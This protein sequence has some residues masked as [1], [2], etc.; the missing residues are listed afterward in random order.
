MKI[1][2]SY[3]AKAKDLIEAGLYPISISVQF[4]GFSKIKYPTFGM[5]GPNYAMLKMS[6]E[7][8]YKIFNKQLAGLD[9]KTIYHDLE[10]TSQGQ[11]VVL[12][13]YEADINN[14][15]RK[16]VGEWFNQKLGIEV[17]EYEFPKKE[18]VPPKPKSRQGD[19]F[20]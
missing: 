7:D 8:Y 4:P 15:H 18:Y 19:L 11:D 20:Q 3:H 16:R 9:V 2:T 12:L 6:S 14:C 13:C 10:R 1:F 17:K 5:L